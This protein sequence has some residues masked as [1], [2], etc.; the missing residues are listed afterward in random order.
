MDP[1]KNNNISPDEHNAEQEALVEA[2]S[3]EV[4]RTIVADLGLSEEDNK[5]LVD[6]LV[7]R[8]IDYRKKLST[9]VRQKIDWRTKAQGANQEQKP[10]TV[11]TTKKADFDP[12]QIRQET[13]ATVRQELEQRDLD[14]MTHPDSIKEEIKK[15]AKAQGISVRVAEKDSYIQFKLEEYKKEER[16][17][18]AANNGSPK[19]KTG[20]LVDTSKPLDA[21]DFDFSTEEGR[22]AWQDA[23]KARRGT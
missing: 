3:D 9:A 8:E 18:E 2:Q 12:E 23:K 7:N 20:I 22:K 13:A 15:L 17:N 5:E 11:T 14:E 1:E 21:K 6:K 19:G 4:R 16:A 10:A